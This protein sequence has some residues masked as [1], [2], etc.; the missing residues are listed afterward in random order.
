MPDNLPVGFLAVSVIVLARDAN[1][2]GAPGRRVPGAPRRRAVR[3]PVVRHA[4]Q[5]NREPLSGAAR[6]ENGAR[7]EGEPPLVPAPSRVNKSL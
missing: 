7:R 5:R 4:D 3:G 1:S 2:L 6:G